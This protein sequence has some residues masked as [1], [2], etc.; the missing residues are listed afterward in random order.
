MILLV[1]FVQVGDIRRW[2]IV[3]KSSNACAYVFSLEDRVWIFMA[4]INSCAAMMTASVG[5]VFSVVKSCGRN[6]A[7][8]MTINPPVNEMKYLK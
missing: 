4:L 8:P 3:P 5:V 1:A 6:L 7:V 2:K